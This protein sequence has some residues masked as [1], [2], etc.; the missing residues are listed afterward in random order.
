MTRPKRHHYLPECYL[1]GFC[2]DSKLYVYDRQ[3]DE[4]RMQSPKNSAVEGH[5]YSLETESGE[6]D[7]RIEE[8]LLSM[9]DGWFPDVIAKVNQ[10][11]A[12]QPDDKDKLSVFVSFL[13]FR[14]PDHEK[15]VNEVFEGMMQQ[16][17]R[18]THSGSKESRAHHDQFC[19]KHPEFKDISFEDMQHAV[20]SGDYRVIPH[21]G[22]YLAS[23]V[24][25]GKEVAHYFRQMDWMIAHTPPGCAFI[26]TDCPFTLVSPP[27]HDPNGFWGVGISTPGAVKAI[28][29]SSSAFLFMSDHGEK[30]RHVTLDSENVRK[31]NLA[32]AQNC[33]NYLFGTSR[34]LLASLVKRTGISGTKKGK[35][36]RIN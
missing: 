34:E 24:N 31:A 22:F 21:R 23:M 4:Y 20:Q 13:W 12:M 16:F 27:G 32:I 11:Q 10:G 9:I 18:F 28:P 8:D 17:L 6:K 33:D 1:K 25:S 30:M 35:R 5:R 29:L 15:M 36:A 19:R 7:P 3:L 2:E 26:T 14:V